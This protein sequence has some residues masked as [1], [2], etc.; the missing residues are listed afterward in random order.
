[1]R[2]FILWINNAEK[3]HAVKCLVLQNTWQPV[4]HDLQSQKVKKCRYLPG[5]VPG[6]VTPGSE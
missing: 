2:E 6:M 1:M 4:Q 5:Y 3:Q